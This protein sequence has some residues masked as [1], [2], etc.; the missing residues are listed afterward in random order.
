MVFFIC[1]S[2]I[3]AISLSLYL[4]KWRTPEEENEATPTS[5][6]YCHRH[7]LGVSKLKKR[8]P[9]STFLHTLCFLL[10]HLAHSDEDPSNQQRK[11]LKVPIDQQKRMTA[12][13]PWEQ[14]FCLSPSDLLLLSSNLGTR[15]RLRGVDLSHPEISQF[16]DVNRKNN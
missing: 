14:C 10:S 5:Q 8:R 11:R 2:H 9:H 6:C 7:H 1:A 15:F 4:I 13:L 3:L 16:Q 12:Y